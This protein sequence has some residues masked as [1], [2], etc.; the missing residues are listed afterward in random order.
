MDVEPPVTAGGE[1]VNPVN[2]SEGSTVTLPVAAID[3]VAA[4]TVTGV[5]P[6]TAAAVTVKVC[7]LMFAGTIRV[8]GTGNAAGLLLVRLTMNPPEGALPLSPTQPV[9]VNPETTLAGLKD[10]IVTT[11][12]ATVRTADEVVPLGSF[13]VKLTDVLADT[14]NEETL[15]VPLVAAPAMVKLAG[16]VAA[17]GLLL[18]R[19]MLKPA[20]GAGPLRI[21]VATE[22]LPPVSVPGTNVNDV[23][24]AGLTV[25][26]ALRLF[27]SSVAF[28]WT[29]SA[30]AT[31][32][33]VVMKVVDDFPAEIVTVAGTVTDGLE[34][35]REI[36]SPPEGAASLIATVPVDLAP[37]VMVAGVRVRP[38]SL[39]LWRLTGCAGAGV[40]AE[41]ESNANQSVQSTA[42]SIAL[43][44]R[45][46][47][48]QTIFSR[49]MF[50]PRH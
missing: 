36:E 23:N 42:R 34:L 26:F 30:V 9:V 44:C 37:P 21:T 12:G 8:A 2:P 27:P 47:V 35:V 50:C 28:T 11:G 45:Q 4:V 17:L 19:V 1:K 5:E 7:E 14:G 13:A 6:A 25:K 41:N 40:A 33:E 15:N 38:E 46:D 48:S 16:T 32:T 29:F 3:P 18:V 43:R 10:S 20:V 22:L 31:P 49:T 24:T 39:S